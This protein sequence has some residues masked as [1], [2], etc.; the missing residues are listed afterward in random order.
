MITIYTLHN[1]LLNILMP[2]K[3][4]FIPLLSFNLLSLSLNNPKDWIGITDQ[5]MGGVSDLTI[6]HSDGIFYMKGNVST[7][8]VNELY[9]YSKEYL[10]YMI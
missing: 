1:L 6:S 5:V 8:N 9:E 2:Y 4:L 3:F 7:D 10:K